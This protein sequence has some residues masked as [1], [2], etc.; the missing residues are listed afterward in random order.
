[1]DVLSDDDDELIIV[2][3]YVHGESLLALLRTAHKAKQSISVPI[4]CAIVAALLEGLHAAH[5]AQNE[6][7]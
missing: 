6:K 2:M 1:L 4:G 7:G 3:E 5:E